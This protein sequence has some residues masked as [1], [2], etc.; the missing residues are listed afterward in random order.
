MGY[1][2]ALAWSQVCV[3]VEA[4]AEGVLLGAGDSRAVFWLSAPINIARVPLAWWLCHGLGWGPAG[5]WWAINLTSLLKATAK[6][7]A[8]G[9]GGWRRVVV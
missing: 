5:V 6:A 7:V 3:A 4:L 8:V 1:A 9:R 2:H